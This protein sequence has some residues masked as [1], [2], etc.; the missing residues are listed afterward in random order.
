MV[1]S[2]KQWF[3][4]QGFFIFT[5]SNVD[6]LCHKSCHC[7]LMIINQSSTLICNRQ[8]HTTKEDGFLLHGLNGAS[9]CNDSFLLHSKYYAA[10]EVLIECF[11]VSFQGF[12]FK[13]FFNLSRLSVIFSNLHGNKLPSDLHQISRRLS[14]LNISNNNVTDLH[15]LS[16][17][18]HSKIQTLD[19][20]R[21]R[22]SVVEFAPKT[23]P[24]L[25][26]L[27]VQQN[28][29][30]DFSQLKNLKSLIVLDTSYNP[31]SFEDS[32]LNELLQLKKLMLRSIPAVMQFD[33]QS[34]SLN[35]KCTVLPSNVEVLDLSNNQLL[36]IPRCTDFLKGLQKLQVLLV[37]NNK[38][39]F[40]S[41]HSFNGG[42][43]DKLKVL[44]LNNNSLIRIDPDFL[45]AINL[46]SL[47][48]S[49]NNLQ[50]LPFAVMRHFFE[51]NAEVPGQSA[52]VS[53]YRQGLTLFAN[54]WSCDCYQKELY[55]WVIQHNTSVSIKCHIPERFK[56][57]L[58]HDLKK[59]DLICS[60]ATVSVPYNA[61]KVAEYA[62]G[63]LICLSSGI[64]KPM[65]HWYSPQGKIMALESQTY[66][67]GSA[68][69][70]SPFGEYLT[71]KDIRLSKTGIF[72]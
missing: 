12:N 28:N 1:F 39:L 13:Q 11:N 8:L 4:F 65:V 35:T 19:L 31:L 51:S 54:L 53:H 34:C 20:S 62:E 41:R 29:I 23:F 36:Q 5:W 37:E 58:I 18:Q 52:Y 26:Y 40:I 70:L 16:N 27:F 30:V 64:P 15:F 38:I 7:N 3:I 60:N 10:S 47:I 72:R 42:C 57:Q 56:D 66:E 21:N 17:Y 63:T 43:Y 69:T 44:S 67:K 46:R 6:Y 45:A 48:L 9:Q 2:W 68:Y 14:F 55:D 59:T 25:R 24:N 61:T 32:K 33:Y 22:I 50:H 49:N 71:I